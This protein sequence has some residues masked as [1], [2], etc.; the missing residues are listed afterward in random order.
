MMM[1][2]NV[3]ALGHSSSI[4]ATG[5]SEALATLFKGWDKLGIFEIC[6]QMS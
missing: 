1:L 2:R 6:N 5:N 3:V 4:L